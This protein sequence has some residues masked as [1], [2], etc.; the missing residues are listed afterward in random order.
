MKYFGKYRGIIVKN[1]LTILALPPSYDDTDTL[2]VKPD[3]YI[4]ERKIILIRT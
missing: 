2:Y 3:E 4:T 1:Q